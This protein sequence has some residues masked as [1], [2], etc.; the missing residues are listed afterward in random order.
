MKEYLKIKVGRHIWL[1]PTDI[2]TPEFK[3]AVEKFNGT[4]DGEVVSF[5]N[6]EYDA[7]V[8]VDYYP[9][10]WKPF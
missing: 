1:V 8:K 2:V 7:F 5:T 4:D 6:E 10:T 9:G 3:R